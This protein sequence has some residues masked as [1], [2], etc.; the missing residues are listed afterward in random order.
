[1]NACFDRLPG[2]AA[3]NLA[4]DFAYNALYGPLAYLTQSFVD[5]VSIGCAGF[6]KG[7]VQPFV[8]IGFKFGYGE[9]R[10]VRL[11]Q[12][13][14][15]ILQH[16]RHLP[17][18]EA[19][20]AQVFNEVLQ[21]F[22]ILV[23]L[24]FERVGHENNAV[25][26]PEHKFPGGVVHDLPGNGVELDANGHVHYLA[27]IKRQEVE[28]QRSVSLGVD[29]HHLTANLFGHRLV[30]IEQ[31]RGLA[32]SARSIIDYLSLDFVFAQIYE[33][34]GPAPLRSPNTA[35]ISFI[36]LPSFS[37]IRPSETLSLKSVMMR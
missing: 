29:G 8:Q 1:M 28:K 9:K 14:F 21:A 31:I 7:D 37:R 17:D 20:V 6:E 18:R 3:G 15:V 22:D 32:P 33:R 34:H 4:A 36:A 24:D 26:S 16:K 5:A 25:N 12:I 13:T 30:Y 19:F 11:H 27:D 23:L 10:D 35:D 2:V